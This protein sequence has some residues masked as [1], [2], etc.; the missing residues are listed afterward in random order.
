MDDVQKAMADFL[1]KQGV[2]PC[3]PAATKAEYKAARRESWDTAEQRRMRDDV[4][5]RVERN[6]ENRRYDN[7]G[8]YYFGGKL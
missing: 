3:P 8:V 6:A 2:T 4:A 7:E 1:A 5:N